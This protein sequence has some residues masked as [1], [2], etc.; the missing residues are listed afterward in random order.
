MNV[1]ARKHTLRSTRMCTKRKL[2]MAYSYIILRAVAQKTR[3]SCN[4]FRSGMYANMRGINIAC[5]ARAHT[6][7]TIATKYRL[8]FVSFSCGSVGNRSRGST[9]KTRA[10]CLAFRIGMH[11]NAIGHKRRVYTPNQAKGYCEIPA[12]PFCPCKV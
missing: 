5:L 11:T 4:T 7:R 1:P 6:K 12:L 10:S 8:G 9:Q 3:I 2:P